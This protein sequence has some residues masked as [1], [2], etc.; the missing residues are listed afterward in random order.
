MEEKT[1][2]VEVLLERAQAYTK[3]SI[4]LFK[5]KATDRLAGVLSN[6]AS[7]VIIIAVFVLF[8]VNLNIGV[9]L[10]VGE[11]IG[12]TWLGFILIA[13][14]YALLGL[15]IFLFRDHLIKKP[16]SNSIINQLLDDEIDND[17]KMSD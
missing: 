11:L 13:A 6:L 17:Q 5:F 15:L 2:P 4:K 9:A 12:K 1:T 3:T 7:Q 8:F 14:F 16:V 10:L